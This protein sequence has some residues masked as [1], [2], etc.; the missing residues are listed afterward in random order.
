MPNLKGVA[1]PPFAFPAAVRIFGSPV[2]NFPVPSNNITLGLPCESTSESFEPP[3]GTSGS[4]V[5]TVHR[6][7]LRHTGEGSVPDRRDPTALS[8]AL[9]LRKYELM[10]EQ[11]QGHHFRLHGSKI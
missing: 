3:R 4:L 9:S 2:L 10:N 5:T 1:L 8:L 11:R 6:V 7:G